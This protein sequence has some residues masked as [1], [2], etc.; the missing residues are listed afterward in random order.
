[1]PVK[2]QHIKYQLFKFNFIFWL[3]RIAFLVIGLSSELNLKP[4]ASWSKKIIIPESFY[5]E[6]YILNA[7]GALR[8]LVSFLGCCARAPVHAKIV[9]WLL[10]SDICH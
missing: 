10:L 6:I 2:G 7:A 3:A 4:R 8:M 5:T 1:V 9:L